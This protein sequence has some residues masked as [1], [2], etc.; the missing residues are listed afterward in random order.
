V[1]RLPDISHAEAV[2]VFQKLG[3]RIAR[4]GKHTIMSNGKIRLTI[5]RHN[6]INPFTMG[7]I[8]RDA[9]LTPEQFKALL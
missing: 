3:F 2:R 8:A 9:G 6:S 7:E 1:P 4:E 5:P